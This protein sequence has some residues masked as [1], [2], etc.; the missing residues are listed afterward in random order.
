MVN[1]ERASSS[2]NYFNSHFYDYCYYFKEDTTFI[3]FAFFTR[4]H[5]MLMMS[6]LFLDSTYI[7]ETQNVL[8]IE[9][10]RES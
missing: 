3:Y 6:I 10:K 9:R 7:E 4:H 2:F 1:K 8:K 5:F